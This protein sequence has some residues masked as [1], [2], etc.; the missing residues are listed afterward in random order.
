MAVAETDRRQ[1]IEAKICI[2]I[3]VFFLSKEMYDVNT[4][5]PP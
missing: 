1:L 5:A 2:M 4:K 3:N